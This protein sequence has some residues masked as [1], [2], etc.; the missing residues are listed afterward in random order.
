MHKNA[1][2]FFEVIEHYQPKF[3]FSIEDG[4]SVEA[5]LS[6]SERRT[7]GYE[8]KSFQAGSDFLKFVIENCDSNSR[9]LEVGAGVSTLAFCYSGAQHTS[10]NPDITSNDLIMAFAKDNALLNGKLTFVNKSS[11]V[12]IIELENNS[13]D[14]AFIDGNH[15]FPYPIIDFHFIHSKLKVGGK[16]LLDDTHIAS[17]KLLVEYLKVEGSYKFIQGI[18]RTALFEK[19]DKPRTLG[20]KTQEPLFGICF[21]NLNKKEPSSKSLISRFKRSLVRNNL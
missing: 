5:F 1:K 20:W 12:G 6:E 16:L 2:K 9:T 18:K 10:V 21:K 8:R 14:M 19:T 11:D 17:V 4:S 3:Q 15:S 7:E 13:Y